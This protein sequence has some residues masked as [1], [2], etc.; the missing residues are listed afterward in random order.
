M[1]IP[2]IH[3]KQTPARLGIDADAGTQDIQQPRAQYEM[4]TVRPKQDIQS[5][6][7]ELEIDQSQAWDALGLGNILESL[8]RIYTNSK[9]VAIQ[10]VAKKVQ[11]GNRM[12]ASSY[13]GENVIAALA[14]ES[15]TDNSNGID[16]YGEA[17][18]LNVRESYTAHKA[19]INTTPGR[20]E[21]N[22]QPSPPIIKYNRG[23]LDIY[24][25]TWPSIEFS[26]PQIDL[27]F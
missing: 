23:K 26:P 4:K 11:D 8:Q 12:A 24:M 2:Q 25:A 1:L 22:T 18:F 3:F 15:T 16:F 5:P 20:V 6:R 10:G 9:Q 14:K 21:I 13:T 19:E 27:K 7:G 17:S